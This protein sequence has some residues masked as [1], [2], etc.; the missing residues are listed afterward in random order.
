MPKR[1][2]P[3]TGDRV[4]LKSL[5]RAQLQEFMTGM[6]KDGAAGV[7][8]INGVSVEDTRKREMQP[9]DEVFMIT[10]GGG[11]YGAA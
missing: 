3:M 11:G 2:L 7:F 4:D 5:D 6:G 1:G 8:Q 10:P 9:D